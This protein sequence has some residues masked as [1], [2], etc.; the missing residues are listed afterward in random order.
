M[1]RVVCA[2]IDFE[3][4]SEVVRRQLEEQLGANF[5]FLQVEVHTR[6]ELTTA[7]KGDPK[8]LAVFLPPNPYPWMV[9]ASGGLPCFMLG[10]SGELVRAGALNVVTVPFDCPPLPTLD[11]LVSATKTA[12]DAGET[13]T[14]PGEPEPTANTVYVAT[15]AAFDATLRRLPEEVQADAAQLIIDEARKR[16]VPVILTDQGENWREHLLWTVMETLMEY[17]TDT[18]PELIDE[19]ERRARAH[20]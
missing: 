11:D 13:M 16:G 18:E 5:I 7:I 12:F 17:L 19:S 4:I 1:P 9:A 2:N 14:P 6:E 10:E 20:R 8:T 15:E 3:G